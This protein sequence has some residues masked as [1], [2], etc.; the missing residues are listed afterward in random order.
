[1][2]NNAYRR[3]G[4]TVTGGEVFGASAAVRILSVLYILLIAAVCGGLIAFVPDLTRNPLIPLLVFGLIIAFELFRLLWTY[5]HNVVVRDDEIV[6]RRGS[7]V[8]ARYPY[9][10]HTFTSSVNDGASFQSVGGRPGYVFFVQKEG[11]A[12]EKHFL[13]LSRRD[14]SRLLDAMETRA[15]RTARKDEAQ[16]APRTVSLE[17]RSF[18][19][20]KQFLKKYRTGGVLLAAAGLFL[21]W[22]GWHRGVEEGWLLFVLSLVCG[23]ASIVLLGRWFFYS[24]SMPSRVTLREGFLSLDNRTIATGEIRSVRAAS[25][26]QTKGDGGRKLEIVTDAHGKETWFL[27]LYRDAKPGKSVLPL[28]DYREIVTCLRAA[29]EDRPDVFRT[30][31]Q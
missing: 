3:P 4:E 24:R 13:P 17:T 2:D 30:E 8:T 12:R 5:R 28:D 21:A 25:A 6:F 22:R 26:L 16:G 23:V 1:M 31:A 9:A 19:L 20:H 29:F 7:R 10:G 27:G 15:I 11:G 18:T 14:F